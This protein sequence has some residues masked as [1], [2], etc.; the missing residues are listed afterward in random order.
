MPLGE[1]IVDIPACVRALRR[2]GYAG[3]Y[4]VEHEPEDHDP[5]EKCREMLGELRSL[6]A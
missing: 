1:G 5:S 2:I 6:L 4:T 3:A